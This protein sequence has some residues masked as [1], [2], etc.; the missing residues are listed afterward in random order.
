MRILDAEGAVAH[1]PDFKS[2]EPDRLKSEITA[3][4]VEGGLLLI[5]LFAARIYLL[6]IEAL[7]PAHLN[8]S[9]NHR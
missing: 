6:G 2:G 5:F 4:R 8:T 7:L 9:N 1:A 3:A